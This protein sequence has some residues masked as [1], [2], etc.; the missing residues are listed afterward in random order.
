[1]ESRLRKDRPVGVGAEVTCLFGDARLKNALHVTVVS[2]SPIILE[3]TSSEIKQF[4]FPRPVVLVYKEGPTVLRGE[5]EAISTE[6]SGEETTRVHFTK[7]TWEE[8]DRRQ[9]PRLQVNLPIHIRAVYES[10]AETVIS[11]VEGTTLDLSVGG[12]RVQVNHPVMAG[13]L[14]EF[15]VELSDFDKARALGIVVHSDQDGFLGIA[16]MDYLGAARSKLIEFTQYK[17][18]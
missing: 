1:V 8:I 17:A 15:S 4:A 7:I 14:V 9:Y 5:G 16:F 11:V 13:S 10:R 18:A 2:N 3:G 12:S 6:K